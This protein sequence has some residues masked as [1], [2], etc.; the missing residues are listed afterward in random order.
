VP[1]GMQM[2]LVNAMTT[3]WIAMAIPE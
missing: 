2:R 3:E 1:M